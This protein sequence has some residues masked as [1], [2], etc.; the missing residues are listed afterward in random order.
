MT[1][2]VRQ[3]FGF[4]VY[5]LCF[6]YYLLLLPLLD[7]N[8]TDER[9]R[10]R[11]R[12]AT[13]VAMWAYGVRVNV[14][15][16]EH[17]HSNSLAIIVANHSSWFD[18]LALIASLEQPIAFVAN[19]KYFKYIGLGRVLR[20]LGSVSVFD[21]DVTTSLRECRDVLARGKWLVIYPEGTR[22]ASLLPFRRGAAV[23][24]YQT[25]VDIQPIVIRGAG[26]ILPRCHSLLRV[27]PGT[28]T[29]G[30][31][32]R[33]TGH[34][35]RSSAQYMQQIQEC[36]TGTVEATGAG[37]TT[38]PREATGAEPA[39]CSSMMDEMVS[40]SQVAVDTTVSEESIGPFIGIDVTNFSPGNFLGAF[41][42]AFASMMTT[43][44]VV[45]SLS[46]NSWIW[47]V[48][49]MLLAVTLIQWLAIL[50]EAGHKTLFRS[51]ILNRSAGYLAG[52][53]ALIPG[54]CWWIVHA[55]HHFWTG[56][57]NLDMTTESLV[58]RPL[59]RLE[60]V[61]INTCWQL[62][63]PLFASL[64][65]WNN[66]WNLFRLR[67]IFPR[68]P[69]RRTVTL[70]IVIYL[71]VYLTL[72]FGL[73]VNVIAKTAGLAMLVT[74]S[75]QDLLILSQHTHIPMK[76]SEG[77]AVQ[78]FT[79]WQQEVFT[80]S[81]VFPQWFARLVLLNFD[82]H[83]LHHMLP[84]IPGYHLHQLKDR[85]TANCIVWWRWILRAKSVRG[86]VLLFQNRDQTGF[87]F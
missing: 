19:Q 71:I 18:Q 4:V 69:Q 64:Y 78:R 62:W 76:L 74:L 72:I 86:E 53:F 5:C 30:A 67:K 26:E 23:L 31:L 61:V 27:Q 82:A 38:S 56:W 17:L 13:R 79:P 34:G 8:E 39:S 15:G 22:S 41:Y 87:H 14:V 40:V 11:L 47:F 58:P 85:E 44:S 73:G 83:G 60:R 63:I 33:L 50:H 80:R 9:F 77:K 6:V 52:F 57:Q 84:R 55:K 68:S 24:A 70:N 2:F 46:M 81:L 75:L 65:R 16:R 42:V 37:E 10:S 25:G 7:R 21:R 32:P 3:I 20:K 43:V 12:K 66:Y 45:M 1:K 35:N 36:F 49:Q 51:R 54:D 59:S 28:I 48:G 29:L